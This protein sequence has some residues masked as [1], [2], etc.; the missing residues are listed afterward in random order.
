MHDK[1]LDDLILFQIVDVGRYY[2]M[3]YLTWS[4]LESSTVSQAVISAVTIPGHWPPKPILA[5]PAETYQALGDGIAV[6]LPVEEALIIIKH[7]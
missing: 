6:P 3:Y 1:V 4:C 5:M 7:H 2:P